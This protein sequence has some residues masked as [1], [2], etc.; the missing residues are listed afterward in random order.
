MTILRTDSFRVRSKS[1]L[2]S[3]K[4]LDWLWGPSSLLFSDYYYS[5]PGIKA[6]GA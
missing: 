3:P 2:S 5:F 6:A 1:F 4:S